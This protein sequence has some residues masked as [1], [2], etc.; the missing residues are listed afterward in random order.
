MASLTLAPTPHRGPPGEHPGP[1]R[2][3]SSERGTATGASSR[4]APADAAVLH[5]TENVNP[6]WRATLDGQAPG[7]GAGRRVAAGLP[8]A[9]RRRRRR[10]P[11]VH[12]RR[13]LPLGAPRRRRG[14]RRP[15]PARPRPHRARAA[16]APG[17]ALGAAPAAWREA[18]GPAGAAPGPRRRRAAARWRGG[19]C[20]VPPARCWPGVARGSSLPAL[21]V[22]LVLTAVGATLAAALGRQVSPG[23][24]DALAGLALGLVAATLLQG[25]V[26]S[27][28]PPPRPARLVPPPT[29]SSDDHR[30]PRRRTARRARGMAVPR[31]CGRPRRRPRRDVAGGRSSSAGDGSA[32]TTSSSPSPGCR[33]TT[34]SHRPA[35]RRGRSSSPGPSPTSHRCRGRWRRPSPS[36]SRPRPSGSRGPCCRGSSPAAGCG[37]RS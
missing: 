26:P 24:T 36:C 7:P 37:C 1:P 29:R 16:T 19:R 22:V 12:P 23:P 9:R 33:S 31:R 8:A 21:A 27:P 25:G 13:A 32:R 34:S 14:G 3:S 28:S 2:R 11:G 15:P 30:T 18:T 20:R 5:L 17:V 4:W 10:G 6:G 35:S